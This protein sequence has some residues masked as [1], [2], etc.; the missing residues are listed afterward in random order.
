MIKYNI[1]GCS[2]KQCGERGKYLSKGF[3]LMKYWKDEK[4]E[5]Y[6]DDFGKL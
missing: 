2:E 3:I 4:Y 5:K 6:W 1:S